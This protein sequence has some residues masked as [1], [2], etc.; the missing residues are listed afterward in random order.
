MSRHIRIA[1]RT[2]VG[3]L[4]R[5]GDL[6]AGFE[7]LSRPH[8]LAGI[9]GH[10]KIQAAR[11]PGYAR[12]VAVSYTAE[13]GPY[14]LEIQGRIDGVYEQMGKTVLEEIKTTQTDL[15]RFIEQNDA[16][17]WA[18]LK[19]YAALFLYELP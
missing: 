4:L 12:E 1:V 11:P 15:D 17:H 14:T 8:G 5:R 3:H 13:S 7:G 10:Q 16:L 2:L 18:Q 6:S 19:V 9:R